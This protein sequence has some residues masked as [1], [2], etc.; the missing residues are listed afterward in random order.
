MNKVTE[1]ACFPGLAKQVP[2]VGHN[3]EGEDRDREPFQGLTENLYNLTVFER[4]L[5]Q[6]E[7]AS[8]TVA[9]VKNGAR[10]L[11]SAASCHIGIDLVF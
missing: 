10:T 2:V 6:G 11:G 4:G 1:R 8:R 9:K 5:K 7:L 3:A